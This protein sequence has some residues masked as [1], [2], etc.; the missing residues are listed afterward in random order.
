M[1]E[2]RNER[3]EDPGHPEQ[4]DA[5]TVETPESRMTGEGA[6]APDERAK[7]GADGPEFAPT[8]AGG[9]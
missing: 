9:E 8:N 7:D 6:P 1:T 4:R 3:P 2:Q 5:E